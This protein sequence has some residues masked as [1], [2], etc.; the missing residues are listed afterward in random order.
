MRPP[1]RSFL[2]PLRRFRVYIGVILISWFRRGVRIHGKAGGGRRG[3]LP[4]GMRPRGK[5]NTDG[6]DSVVESG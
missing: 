5:R 2:L 1:L 3:C 4:S 6:R